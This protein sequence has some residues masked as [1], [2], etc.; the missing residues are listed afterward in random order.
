MYSNISAILLGD[1]F[2][3]IVTLHPTNV[4]VCVCVNGP[5][6]SKNYR[7]LLL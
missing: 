2:E 6:H 3:T 1:D 5:F 4:F 7:K